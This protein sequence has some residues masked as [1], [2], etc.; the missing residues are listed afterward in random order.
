MR[1]PAEKIKEAILNPDPELREAAVYYFARSYS[2][3][4]TLMPLVIQAFE[5]FGLQAF[6]IY[7]FLDDLVQTEESVAWLIREIERVNPDADERSSD[8][9]TACVGALRHADA[10]L[11]NPHHATIERMQRLDDNSKKIIAQRIF[12]SSL[13]PDVLWDD[14]TDFCERQDREDASSDEEEF[15]EVIADALSFFPDQ[16]AAKVLDILKQ[17]E[18]VSGWLEFMCVRIA[19]R[20]HLEPAIPCLIDLLEDADRWSCDEALWEL[21]RIGTDSVV[22]QLASRYA[23]GGNGLRLP[24]AGLLEDIHSD[25]SV[26][27]CLNLL[28]KEQDPELRGSLIESI[29]MN[30]SPA[31]IEPARQFV[32]STPKNPE[33]LE[34]RHA[35]LVAS[36]MMGVQFPEFD[37]WAEDS[38]TDREFRRDWYKDH[39]LVLLANS[40]EE[41]DDELSWEDEEIEGLIADERAETIVRHG[42][43]VGRNDPCPCGSGKKYKK[44]CMKKGVA[45]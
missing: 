22:E 45:R 19:G 20:I 38:K 31:G 27:T 34:V 11:L 10:A 44:C 25:L 9:F 13:A 1:L 30:F 6:E 24:I 36:K 17:G 4:P 7:S 37:A 29:L 2:P 3:D 26:Q 21:K 28:E 41:R 33:T 35:L 8:F 18:K 12:I 39:P 40:F 32:L 42:P 5:R 14:L 15:G 43:R 16:C 23:A